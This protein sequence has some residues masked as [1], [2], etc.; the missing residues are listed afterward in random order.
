MISSLKMSG[1][2]LLDEFSADFG[3]LTVVIG[4]NATGKSTLIDALRLM[5]ECAEFPLQ[6]ALDLHGWA[7]S[8]LNASSKGEKI[9]WRLAFS[10]PKHQTRWAFL[11]LHE[12]VGYTYEVTI[13]IDRRLGQAI[14]EQEVLRL[15]EPRS[16]FAGPFKFFEVSGD[17]AV[18]YDPRERRL[19][20]FEDVF[21]KQDAQTPSDGKV[22]EAGKADLPEPP[23]QERALWLAQMRFHKEFPV[24]SWIRTLLSSLVFYPGF[25]VGRFSALKTK[26]A[27]IRPEATLWVS[28]ENLGTVLHEMFTRRDSHG[29]AQ[30]LKD[31]IRSAYP[32]F[33]EITAETTYGTPPSVLV[34]VYEKGM[35]RPME[36][37]DLSDGMLRFLCLGAALLNPLPPPFVAIDEPETGLHPRLMPI[38]ADMIKA[39]SERAQVLVT[40]HSPDLL[41]RFD[42]NDIA[43][44]ARDG[45][46]AVWQRPGKRAS[47][48]KMLEGVV[49]DSLG[50]LLRTG[51]LEAVE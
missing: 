20:P 15:T 3:P 23:P 36:L 30:M 39:A 10:K 43:V 27:E 9:G 13:G 47:L 31:F 34:R 17:H 29:S 8:L 28:G 4:A 22:T 14:P 38:I 32:T 35:L 18:I 1:Y 41:N 2:R 19:V 42:L 11:P 5:C 21:P 51:E 40:T 45:P 44:M 48:R 49:G 7:P 6:K 26:A 37:W 12:N 16:G 50:D 24:V 25:E 33:E 46:H